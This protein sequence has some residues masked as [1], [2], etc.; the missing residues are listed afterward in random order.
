MRKRPDFADAVRNLKK[1]T[2]K[3]LET[4]ILDFIPADRYGKEQVSHFIQQF[5]NQN[6]TL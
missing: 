3:K 6:E 2:E 4:N 5:Q 1:A